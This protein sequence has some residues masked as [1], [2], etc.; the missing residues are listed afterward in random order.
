MSSDACKCGAT[1]TWY[2]ECYKSKKNPEPKTGKG[3][4]LVWRRVLK[5]PHAEHPRTEFVD[6]A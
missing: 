4:N 6:L 5:V 1:D 2:K 3:R